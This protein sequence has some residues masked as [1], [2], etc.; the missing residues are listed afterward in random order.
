[1]QHQRDGAGI[2]SLHIRGAAPVK[3]GAFLGQLK[4]WSGPGLAFDRHDINMARQHH[5]RHIGGADDSEKIG[6]FARRIGDQRAV[7]TRPTQQ[8]RDIGHQPE[9]A[10]MADGVKFD[11]PFQYRAGPHFMPPKGSGDLSSADFGR[12]APPMPQAKAAPQFSCREMARAQIR[13]LSILRAQHPGGPRRQRTPGKGHPGQQCR[14]YPAHHNGNRRDR[15]EHI[16][17][18]HHKAHHRP[19]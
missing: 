14:Q 1:M 18:F 3:P 16:G 4:R 11:Q 13:A 5:T 6:F 7:D 2:K 19:A 12:A 8:I 10:F 9:V 15:F 17:Q